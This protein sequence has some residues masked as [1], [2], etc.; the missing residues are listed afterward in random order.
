[1]ALVG[2]SSVASLIIGVVLYYF[3]QERLVRAESDLLAQRSATANAGAGE[4]LEGLRNPE[5]RTLPP[6]ETYAEELVRSVS[7]PTG[8][9]VLYI[10][11]GGEPLA[12]RD[13]LGDSVPPGE[14]YER[15][16]PDEGVVDE[17]LEGNESKGRLVRSGGPR[18]ITVWPLAGADGEP[19]GVM[20]YNSPGDELEST[21]AYLRYGILGAILTSVLLSALASYLLTRQITRPLS[22]TRDAAI[23][24]ASG[25]YAATV[26]STLR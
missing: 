7:D 20:V 17:V 11:P 5:D 12:A 9:G 16:E 23:R 8:L 14:A 4:F 3:A 24:V 25:D 10:G 15:L 1:M 26:P 19:R 22:E 21:L 18:Y 2:I 13:G 6:P